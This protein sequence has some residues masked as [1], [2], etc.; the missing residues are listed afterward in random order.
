VNAER[1]TALPDA[2][3]VE[4][5]FE[6]AKYFLHAA[7]Q[8]EAT[9]EEKSRR[10]VR[11]C[12]VTAFTALEAWANFLCFW[13]AEHGDVERHEEAFLREQ[14]LDFTEEGYFT[15]RGSRFNS[16]EQKI[17]FLHWHSNGVPIP[18]D[19]VVWASFLQAKKIR[20]RIVHPK[21][22]Q[23]HYSRQT[24]ASAK[25]C[26]LAITKVVEMLSLA[27]HLGARATRQGTLGSTGQER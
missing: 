5:L 26:L 23:V 20:D 24:V 17:R 16:L 4:H 15:L 8:Y 18:R 7:R 1:E 9:H 3:P 25:S 22:G 13:I 19:D 11:A 2:Y 14:R 6:D 27:E 10:Y 12:I 21:P